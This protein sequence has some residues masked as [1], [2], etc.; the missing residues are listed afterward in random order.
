MSLGLQNADFG[1]KEF[2]LFAFAGMVLCGVLLGCVVFIAW[3]V[4]GPIGICI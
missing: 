4:L 2:F 3:K 1:G